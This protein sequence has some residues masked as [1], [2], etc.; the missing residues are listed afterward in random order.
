M[1]GTKLHN[2]ELAKLPDVSLPRYLLA[3]IYDWLLVLALLA[4]LGFWQ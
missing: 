1:Y 2:A 4:G 3:I